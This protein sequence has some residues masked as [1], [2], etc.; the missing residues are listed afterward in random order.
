VSFSC[1]SLKPLYIEIPQKSH[2]ELPVNIQSL[3]IV[4]RMVDGSYTDLDADSLQKI[5]YKQQ[6]NYDTIINDIQAVDTTLKALGNLLFESGR[7]D[8]VI[9]ENRFLPFEKNAFIT[10]ELTWEEVKTLCDTFDTDAVLSIDHFKTRVITTFDKG[11]YFSQY[12]NQF[13]ERAEATIKISFEAVVRVYDPAKE[14]IESRLI[15][16]DTLVWEDNGSTINDL[17]SR[18]TPVKDALSEVGIAVALEFA[19]QVNPKW[20]QEKRGYFIKGDANLKQAA[21]LV[22]SGQWGPAIM[23]WKETVE[24]TK[25]K[26][27]KSK[28]EFNI[29]LG[30]EML[31]DIDE[32]IKWAL[33]SY[34]TMFRTNTYNYL[35][36]LKRRKIEINN[37]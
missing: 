8:I 25:S 24:N 10:K 6:F 28:A 26:S 35:E 23:L 17:F 9:P 11:S 21:P 18:F 4:A 3:L 37:R 2:Q 34:E 31:G 36:I 30:Y 20:K 5:F 12:E 7:Y 19:N 32:S 27:T 13:Y 33:Q 29:A 22:S 1:V 14:K 16:R 15:M